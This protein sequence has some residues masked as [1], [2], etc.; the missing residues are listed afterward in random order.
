MSREYSE[1]WVNSL[2]IEQLVLY[3]KTKYF[4]WVICKIFVG[5]LC[6]GCS[7]VRA[8]CM[9]ASLYSPEPQKD[10]LL[11]LI[12]KHETMHCFSTSLCGKHSHKMTESKCGKNTYILY[13][14]PYIYIFFIAMMVWS[15]K[16]SL[17][18]NGKDKTPLILGRARFLQLF[19]YYLLMLATFS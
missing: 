17:V 19:I 16:S 10:R 1:N 15:N 18:R 6:F 5:F 11:L 3:S 4:I 13:I 14:Y 9:Q 12:M 2:M 8:I 7:H